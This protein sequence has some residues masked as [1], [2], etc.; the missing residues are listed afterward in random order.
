MRLVHPPIH[1]SSASFDE[2]VAAAK[3]GDAGSFEELV[4]RTS[5]D[6][7]TLARRLVSDDDDAR[8][9]VQDAY[10]RAYRSIG[11]FRGD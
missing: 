7:Y 1:P 2:L 5:A 8:D 10:L 6:T 9:V 3:A 11:T 4:R